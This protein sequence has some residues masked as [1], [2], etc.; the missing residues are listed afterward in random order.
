MHCNS[1]ISHGNI[2]RQMESF[3]GLFSRQFAPYDRLP[4]LCSTCTEIEHMPDI[5]YRHVVVL[6]PIISEWVRECECFERYL[7]RATRRA[8]RFD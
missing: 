2:Q 8:N 5:R 3:Q 6:T 1:I 7:H 4:D